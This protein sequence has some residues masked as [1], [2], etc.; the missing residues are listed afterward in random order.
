MFK[1]RSEA[2]G[3]SPRLGN[4]GQ[5]AERREVMAIVIE[6]LEDGRGRRRA[7]GLVPVLLVT[8]LACNLIASVIVLLG[9]SGLA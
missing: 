4:A 1:L 2:R 3:D 5:L 8:Q 7:G 6:R 9:L